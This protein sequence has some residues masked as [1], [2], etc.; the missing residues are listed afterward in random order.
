MYC[1]GAWGG[2]PETQ[3]LAA[4]LNIT[5]YFYSETFRGWTRF[6]SISSNPNV[7]S[8]YIKYVGD[9]HFQVVKSIA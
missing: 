7:R 1:D 8:L 6:G 3:T 4:L 5:I 9:N 2:D